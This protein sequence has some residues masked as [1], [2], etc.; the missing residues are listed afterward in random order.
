VTARE[1]STLLRIDGQDFVAALQAGRPSPSLL[2]VAGVR[3]ARTPGRV[4]RA[5]PAGYPWSADRPEGESH[6][7]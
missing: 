5:Q 1:D 3:L 4:P 6:E 2:S 7:S